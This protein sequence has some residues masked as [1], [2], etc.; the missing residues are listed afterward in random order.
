MS[1]DNLPGGVIALPLTR[2]PFIPP[3]PSAAVQPPNVYYVRILFPSGSVAGAPTP[4]VIHT[5]QV[6][7]GS[8]GIVIPEGLLYVGGDV[9]GA[10][11]PGV[12]KGDPATVYYEPSSNNLTGYY[13]QVAQLGLGADENGN[14]ATLCENVTLVG[15]AGMNP[16]AG[17]MGVGFGRPRSYG[18]NVFLGAPSGY[19]SYL[20]TTA[21]IWLGYTPQNLP[22]ASAY[23]F[24]ALSPAPVSLPSTSLWETPAANFTLV[25][26]GGAPQTS[27]GNA[28]L[29]T[30]VN[31][32]LLG[33]DSAGWQEQFVGA[34]LTIA[35]PDGNGGTIHSYTLTITGVE[36]PPGAN[37]NPD[38]PKLVYTVAPA[39]TSPKYI[40][41]QGVTSPSFVNTGIDAIQGAAFYFDAHAGQIGFAPY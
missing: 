24:Q 35:W 14:C 4:P 33:L 13:Y 30:G 39:P 27:V 28:I 38:A 21:G 22:N 17:M 9:N 19:S 2:P 1:T 32:M 12:T 3:T 20:F 8:C 41:P 6:D 7:T 29:D 10:L 26:P 23:R 25:P 18:T 11:L 36:A 31:L 5:C 15:A 37:E 40:V 16:T 34:Q